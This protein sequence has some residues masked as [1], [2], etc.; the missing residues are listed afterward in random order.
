[1]KRNRIQ[2]WILL[3]IMSVVAASFGPVVLGVEQATPVPASSGVV[4]D[5]I[6]SGNPEAAPGQVLELVRYTIPAGITLPMHTHPG[7]Q[8]ATIESG[9]L[10]YTVL[11]GEVPLSRSAR[12]G[13]PELDIS[14][15]VESGEVAI[16]PGDSFVE[17][18]G[19]IH[20][21]R[22]LGPEPVVILVSSLFAAGQ[23]PAQ[24]MPVPAES[25]PVS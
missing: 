19:V 23:P 3:R 4:R 10:H 5:V 22:N 11:E 16:G 1:M 12:E 20:F 25:T 13:T 2:I 15:T 17:A 24:V 9:T 7:M 18:E 21:G 14:V 8:V 6:M